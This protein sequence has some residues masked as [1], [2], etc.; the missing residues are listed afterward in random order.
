[1]NNSPSQRNQTSSSDE[2]FTLT[3]EQAQLWVIWGLLGAGVFLIWFADP[4][5]S[6]IAGAR[7][8]GTPAGERM[9]L[10]LQILGVLSFIAGLVQRI[11]VQI[12]K[13]KE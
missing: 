7:S 13:L 9:A 3:P 12:A 11:V 10:T 1:M 4:I 8:P 5:A 6:D 2:P